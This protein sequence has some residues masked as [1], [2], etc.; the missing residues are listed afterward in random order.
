MGFWHGAILWGALA[1]AAPIVIHLLFRPKPR[2]E[3]LPTLRFLR[4]IP[5]SHFAR[6]RGKHLLLLALRT[7]AVLGI[8][9]LLAG[10]FWPG[11]EVPAVSVPTAL[12]VL[13]DTS[14]SMGYRQ[15]GR[16]VLQRGQQI[17]AETVE[18]LPPGSVA[19]VLT[20]SPSAPAT[21]KKIFLSDLR[22]AARRVRDAL[23]GQDDTPLGA[24]LTEAAALLRDRPEP[25]KMLLI[26]T[27]L[28]K[29]AFRN[30][31]RFSAGP[32]V[33]VS[34]LDAG[35]QR[36]ANVFLSVPRVPVEIVPTGTELPLSAFLRSEHAGGAMRLRLSRN[37]RAVDQR[38]V[39]LSPGRTATVSFLLRAD[40]P[41]VWLG[42]LRLQNQ[43]PLPIDNVRYFTVD[44]SPPRNVL[45]IG[46]RGGKNP[47]AFLLG[48]AVAPPLPGEASA[49]RLRSLAPGQVDSAALVETD[50]TILADVPSLRPEQ[51]KHLEEACRGGMGVWIV[52]GETLQP[53]SWNSSEAQQLLPATVERIETLSTP[54]MLA[55]P[56]ATRPMFQPF[57]PGPEANPPLTAVSS[58]R[59]LV[60]RAKASDARTDLAYAD[61]AAAIL[62]RRVGTGQVVLWNFSPAK[63]WSNLARCSGQFVILAQQTARLLANP[64]EGPRQFTPQTPIELPL[65]RGFRRPET[66]LRSANDPSPTLVVPS[67]SGPAPRRLRLP[68]QPIGSYVLTLREGTRT[69]ERGF[70]V[71]LPA[72]E[73]DRTR[74]TPEEVRRLFPDGVSLSTDPAQPISAAS[75]R[76]PPKDLTGLI[77][78]VLLAILAAESLLANRIYRPVPS[79]EDAPEAAGGKESG[80]PH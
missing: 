68:P 4:K 56:D 18:S 38:V 14:A 36:D 37:G 32:G 22:L 44:V 30:V 6:L 69:A 21:A 25:R 72:A 24:A 19:V 34:V 76:A 54:Q 5:P 78:L 67:L 70:S 7:A 71:N 10:A 49:Y 50:L 55:A 33:P 17:A 74:L 29:G 47:T 59:R 31:L 2:K 23:P 46:S 65:P 77:F 28:T 64:P 58:Q 8:V 1:A 79:S 73:S 11:R 57:A 16:T 66:F 62:S 75:G 12:A 39:D 80:S 15:Q 41:G 52:P 51:W 13:L 60:L 43:D 42:R 35:V 63:E 3:I 20:T 40:S 45:L 48:A 27:D 26:V 9:L 61:G 53:S